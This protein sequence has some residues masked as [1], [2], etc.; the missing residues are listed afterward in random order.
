MTLLTTAM[1]DDLLFNCKKKR[2]NSC[3]APRKSLMT[4]LD[5]RTVLPTYIL[6]T[7]IHPST[8]CIPLYSVMKA[9]IRP[10]FLLWVSNLAYLCLSSQQTYYRDLNNSPSFKI[11]SF[12][13]RVATHSH[14]YWYASQPFDIYY[15]KFCIYEAVETLDKD[16]DLDS[17]GNVPYFLASLAEKTYSSCQKH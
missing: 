17:M 12:C 8:T 3:S 5:K 7:V 15:R 6:R 9:Y 14:G 11:L 13:P 4:N 1:N 2:N 16:F 10:N